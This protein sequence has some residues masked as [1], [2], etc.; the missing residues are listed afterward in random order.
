M[1]HTCSNGCWSAD[2]WVNTSF[3]FGITFLSVK[4][5]KQFYESMHLCTGVILPDCRLD[6]NF[7]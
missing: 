3:G 2:S 5:C 6:L 7:Q 4:A 1:K